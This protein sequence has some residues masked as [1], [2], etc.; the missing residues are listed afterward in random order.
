MMD[1]SYF[2]ELFDQQKVDLEAAEARWDRRAAEVSE[3]TVADDDLAMQTV[4]NHLELRGARVLE[5]SFGAGRHLEKFLQLGADISGVEISANMCRY[6]KER[7]HSTGLPWDPEQLLQVPW[8][9][10]DLGAM[11]WVQAF[12]LTFVNMSPAL[13]STSMLKKALD[14][15]RQGL[16][17]ASHSHREDEL[18]TILQDDLGL[19]RRSPGQRYANDLYLTFSIL[20][21][22][23]YFPQLQFVQRKKTSQHTPDYVLERYASWLWRDS[24]VSD[25]NRRQ[26]AKLLEEKAEADGTIS[27]RSRDVIGHL[28]L[29]KTL[30][31]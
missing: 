6:A 19:E 12:D 22:W 31:R 13:S 20:Y 2:S 1:F 14:A 18:L 9:A 16:Y 27:C 25:S 30:R 26:L 29:D 4:T 8:E 28:W 15:T 11:E 10:V 17:I 24:K 23:G 21:G 3:F 7:L 5:I